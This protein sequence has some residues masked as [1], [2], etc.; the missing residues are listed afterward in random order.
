MEFTHSILGSSDYTLELDD[1]SFIFSGTG[2]SGYFEVTTSP[3]FADGDTVAVKLFEGS[4]GGT[5]SDDATLT[6]LDFYAITH[7]DEDLVTL[8]PAFDA[9]T[10]E[11]TA[12][13]DYRFTTASMSNIVRGDSGASVVVTDEFASQDLG[14][15]DSVDD[16][17]LAIG[18][19]TITVEVTAADGETT[20]TY[21]LVVT[22]TAP[23]PLPAH[24][25]TGDIWCATLTVAAV[26]GGVGYSGAQG[27]LSHV[28]F[29]Y[30]PF[31]L[32]ETLLVTDL[33]PGVGIALRIDFH[34]PGETVFNTDD[35]FLYIDGTAFA[36]SDATFSSG[37][38]EWADTGL[39]WTSADTVEVRLVEQSG[40][41]IGEGPHGL[42][43][44]PRRPDHRRPVPADLPL[45]DQARR[46]RPP[47]SRPTTPSCRPAPRPAT[48]TS[49]P[50]ATC[51]TVV[52]CT[53]DTDAVENTGTSGAG[54]GG[55]GVPIYWLNGAKVADDYADFYDGDWDEEAADKNELGANGPDTSQT[56]N[57]P[58]TGCD[59]D[60][61]VTYGA[62]GQSYGLGTSASV[63]TVGRPD[64]SDTGHGPIAGSLTDP[65]TNHPMYGLSAVFGVGVEGAN[66]DPTFPMSTADRSVA[67]NT[68]SRA[69][70]W[71]PS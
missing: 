29:E 53:E 34:P 21:T 43:P 20:V 58:L 16:L 50:T 2:G 14:S 61:T 24:C 13:V 67:E 4:G 70:T 22:R 31:Y 63:V 3:T 6:S 1:E 30:G 46:Q 32:V 12:V 9:G 59:D 62:F 52:G 38:F 48:P 69:R 49:R 7:Q 42:E 44:D 60:G 41:T 8:T 55:A 26:S 39:S 71:A 28:A 27:T 57:Y 23:P 54:T 11:Y 17:E 5:L 47:T 33:Y 68:A 64:S 51:F 65:A 36:F 37:Y 45:L 19:N 10:T 40:T 25:E 18:E 56:A 35:L 66:S 15:D